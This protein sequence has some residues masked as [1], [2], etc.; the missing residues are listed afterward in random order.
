MNHLSICA[1]IKNEAP[2]IAEWIAFHIGQGFDHFYLFDNESTDNTVEIA[3]SFRHLVT[4]ET[5]K[6]VAMQRHVY[7]NFI[8]YQR[9]A[10]V[11][12]AFIDVDEFLYARDVSKGNFREQFE[13]YDLPGIDGVAVNWL[14]FGSSSRLTYSPEPVIQ[15]FTRRAEEVNPHVKS[16][17]RMENVISTFDNV[18]A[19]KTKGYVCDEKFNMLPKQY[20]LNYNGT[21]DLLAVNHY[22]TKSKEECKIRRDAPRADT[23]G[24]REESFFDDHDRNDVE[25]RGIQAWI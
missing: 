16:I 22:V 12:T 20:S 7:D 10:S 18:H 13:A 8:K 17:M 19:Y 6:G 1:I 25:D 15:R 5:V 14:L 3:R 4:V 9:D 11:W 23:G 21:C 24:I 2:Y